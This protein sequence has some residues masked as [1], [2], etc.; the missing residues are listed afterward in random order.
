MVL[1]N[2]TRLLRKPSFSVGLRQFGREDFSHESP[3]KPR[4]FGVWRRVA[5]SGISGYCLYPPS[6]LIN[7]LSFL[8]DKREKEISRTGSV[9]E[10]AAVC[11]TRW[12]F[13]F[14][15]VFY[16]I[17]SDI[18][19]DILRRCRSIIFSNPQQITF[20]ALK[21]GEKSHFRKRSLQEN[22][23]PQILHFRWI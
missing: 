9:G 13:V 2:G 17:S 8:F 23:I 3:L 7:N 5:I 16:D 1:Q 12:L 19:Y 10:V 18:I 21:T 4:L 15:D 22:H 6:C 14:S 11:L 20:S